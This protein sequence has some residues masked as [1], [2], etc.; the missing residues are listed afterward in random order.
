[1]NTE[2]T[3]R[4][5]AFIRGACR[6][7]AYAIRRCREIENGVDPQS[8]LNAIERSFWAGNRIAYIQAAK[9]MVEM[10]RG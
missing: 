8:Q 7:A 3:K 6:Q 2:F 9:R 10:V 4:E 5:L 1:M